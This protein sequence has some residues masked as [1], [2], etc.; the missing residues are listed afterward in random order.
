MAPITDSVEIGRSPEDVFAYARSSVTVELDFAA[1]GI[2]Q[3][4]RPLA[5]MQARKSVTKGQQRLK[6][7]LES[8]AA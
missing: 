1:Y 8:C 4:L 3:L 7:K 5:L 6:D 2:G